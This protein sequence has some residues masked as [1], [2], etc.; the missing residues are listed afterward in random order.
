MDY[1]EPDLKFFL[2]IEQKYGLNDKEINGINYWTLKRN[3]IWHIE[4]CP[5]ELGFD[6][7]KVTRSRIKELVSYVKNS[8]KHSLRCEQKDI[9]VISHPRRVKTERGY[10]DIYTDCWINDYYDACYLE[11]SFE[12][13]HLGPVVSK[14]IIYSDR[15][16]L[17]AALY[18]YIFKI[19]K[20]K[21]YQEYESRVKDEVLPAF[22]ELSEKYGWRSNYD[23]WI[24]IFVEEIIKAGYQKRKYTK[25]IKKIS[26]KVIV[27]VVGYSKICMLIN[28]IAKE[29]HIPTYELQHGT[30]FKEHLA[31]QYS[32]GRQIKLFPDNLLL[33]SDYW[34]KTISVPINEDHIYSVGFPNFEKKINYYKSIS[35]TDKRKTIIF[36]SQGPISRPLATLAQEVA[37]KVSVGEYRIIYKLHPSE[38]STWKEKLPMLVNSDVEVID[39]RAIDLYQLL[40]E[41]DYQVGVYSTA[42]IEGMGFGLRTFIYSVGYYSVMLP[43]IDQGYASLVNSTEELIASLESDAIGKRD[44]NS[45]WKMDSVNNLRRIIDRSIEETKVEKWS[46]YF[47][48]N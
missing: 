22:R 25:L 26:P 12:L 20:R 16:I 39:N 46:M 41:S 18:T 21:K 6:E 32:K 3:G 4:L 40:S 30:L 44:G 34:K 5:K 14:N 29:L 23:K 10:E 28:G 19:L 11:G 24:H 2:D 8:I 13:K 48:N 43:L 27:E 47:E 35:R 38:Y 42:I 36:L 7:L 9:L 33:F 45:F 31:Y 15:I 17:S 1:K 37:K